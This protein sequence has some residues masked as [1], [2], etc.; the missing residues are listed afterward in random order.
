MAAAETQ[1]PRNPW[2]T[3]KPRVYKEPPWEEGYTAS[4]SSHSSDESEVDRRLLGFPFWH[5]RWCVDR[6]EYDELCARAEREGAEAWHEHRLEVGALD[7]H[8]A[9]WSRPCT[10]GGPLIGDD[11]FEIRRAAI[12]SRREEQAEA[13]LQEAMDCYYGHR[14]GDESD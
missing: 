13:L 2:I 14:V 10:M 4:V 5:R 7:T 3:P 9:P 11:D 8:L 12:V 6:G 1:T